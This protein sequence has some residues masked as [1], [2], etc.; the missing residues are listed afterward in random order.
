MNHNNGSVL[1]TA[2]GALLLA[3][4][5]IATVGLMFVGLGFALSTV[6]LQTSAGVEARPTL[7]TSSSMTKKLG[8]DMRQSVHVNVGQVPVEKGV[9]SSTTEPDQQ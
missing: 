8:G 4:A 7:A 3:L 2:S 6:Y 5:I 9:S 1:Q